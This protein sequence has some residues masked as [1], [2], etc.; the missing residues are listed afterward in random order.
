[1]HKPALIQLKSKVSTI[2]QTRAVGRV[3]AT[4]GHTI[5]VSGLE[6]AAQLGD[7][8]RLYRRD[9][10]YLMGDVL[11]LAEDSMTMLPDASPHKIALGDRVMLCGRPL[12]SPD[13]SWLGRVVDPYGAALDGR[14]LVRGTES[15][16]I[17][18]DPPASVSRKAMG[19]RLE[20]GF[21]LFNTLLPIVRGQRVGIF[22]GSGVGK[23]TLMAELI[24]SIETDVV[25]LAL[26]GERGREI[27]DFT[28]KTLGEAGLERTIIV[29][30]S[31]DAAPTARMRCPI[32]AM[33]I[34][35]YFRDIGMQ[36]L[37]VVDSITRFAE[38][39]REVAVSAGEF[40]SLRGFPPSTPVQITK[41]AERSG[42]GLP[43]TG[44]ITAIFNVLVAGS[45]MDEPIADLLRGV[46][47]GHIVLD[48]KLAHQGRFPAVNPLQSVSRSLPTSANVE[49]NTMI[50]QARQ[51]ISKYDASSALIEAG[52]NVPGAD[53]KLDQAIAFQEVFSDFC[54]TRTQCKISDSFDALRLCLRRSGAISS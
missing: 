21:H 32:T 30:A 53:L 10:T 17:Q 46:L 16:E 38:A 18:M 1:M 42:P 50:A 7:R 6:D 13:L 14:S 27:N 29:A 43:E 41:L 22:A 37:L 25:V 39:H 40:P 44:D 4:D 15:L 28:Q 5:Q 54:T 12:V 49:E 23:S 9:G 31:A 51:L 48:R 36:V 47:D 34:A 8:L 11:C 35:E 20:T 33:R 2:A 52:L 19:S 24:Q 26:V 3:L 45:D